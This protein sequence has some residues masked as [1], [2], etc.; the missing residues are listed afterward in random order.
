MEWLGAWLFNFPETRKLEELPE[1]RRGFWY[2]NKKEKLLEG[3]VVCVLPLGKSDV[4]QVYL[5]GTE[6][7]CYL[8]YCEDCSDFPLQFPVGK[9]EILMFRAQGWCEDELLCVYKVL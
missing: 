7:S 5:D 2:V 1:L 3:S 8:S 9:K 6:F 4:L